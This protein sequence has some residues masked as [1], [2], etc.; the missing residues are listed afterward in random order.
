MG[1]V[2][3]GSFLSHPVWAST[4]RKLRATPSLIRPKTSTLQPYSPYFKP[5]S[6]SQQTLRTMH[7]N[8]LSPLITAALSWLVLIAA[9]SVSPSHSYFHIFFILC[10]TPSGHIFSVG[11][12]A[13]ALYLLRLLWRTSLFIVECTKRWRKVR[14][15][16]L[17]STVDEVTKGDPS[18]SS[19]VQAKT[20]PRRQTA[21]LLD[22]A[23]T[24]ILYFGL[25]LFAYI[26]WSPPTF[27]LEKPSVESLTFP[28]SFTFGA[29]TS[30]YQVEGYNDNSQWSRFENETGIERC[31][32]AA[33]VWNRFESD[34]ENLIVAEDGVHLD[35]FRL[36][37]EWSRIEPE[38]G[39][40]D[41]ETLDRY[42]SW[43]A[44]LRRVGIKPM[45]TLHHFTNPIWFE[46]MG[47][48]EN[49]TAPSLIVPFVRKVVERLGTDV[50][51][52]ITMNEI[53]VY[54]GNGYL[55]GEFPPGRKGELGTMLKVVQNMLKCHA[56]MYHA[57]K[58]SNPE[59]SVSIAKNSI[60]YQP[61]SYLDLISIIAATVSDVYYN[62]MPI[63]V[64]ERQGTIDYLGLNTYIRMKVSRLGSFMGFVDPPEKQNDMGWDL[65]PQVV[66]QVVKQYHSYMPELDIIITEHGVA[67]GGMPDSR[68][69]DFLRDSLIGLARAINEE[70]TPVTGYYHWSLVDN[71][72]WSSG[73]APHFGL[74]HIDLPHNQTRS[75][76]EGGKLYREIVESHNVPLQ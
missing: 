50:D 70:E 53:M 31:G 48:F 29:S 51:T 22:L 18:K 76:T 25:C 6:G 1:S 33:D 27:D 42:A 37:V 69:V 64:L 3:W 4:G 66:Y 63:R 30:A 12:L 24:T 39:V 68:R 55:M 57:I 75:I 61:S 11:F 20:A 56:A 46:D 52:Y 71:F 62:A 34:I 5:R 54:A 15:S 17:P 26:L 73:F 72:E 36:S 60:L 23:A 58:E 47:A 13:W 28:P 45:L 8:L 41:E 67:D 35:S 65:E 43:I 19:D 16:S 10:T 59:A 40:F 9:A 7:L 14:Y 2:T 49:E 38:Q 44:F 32:A 21:I 74:Y